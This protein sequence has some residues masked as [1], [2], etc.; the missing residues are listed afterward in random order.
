MEKAA[1]RGV[2]YLYSSKNFIRPIRSMGMNWAGHVASMGDDRR[3]YKAVV[4][5]PEGN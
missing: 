3:V 4:G 5:K 2:S 1:H